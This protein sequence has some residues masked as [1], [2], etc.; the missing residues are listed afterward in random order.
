MSYNLFLDDQRNPKDAFCYDE[1]KKLET[2]SGVPNGCWE[3]VRSLDEFVHAVNTKGVP[4]KVSFDT[5]LH[6]EHMRHFMGE[7]QVSGIYEWQNF[8]HGCGIHC[9]AYLK[10]KLTKDT[11]IKVYVH[12]ANPAGRKII[13][14][15][16]KDFLYD[17]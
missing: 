12:S 3:I 4:S 16:M 11:N 17:K 8:K 1:M 2:L 7:T 9:A 13:K 5:D 15:L 10:S 14:E 6:F